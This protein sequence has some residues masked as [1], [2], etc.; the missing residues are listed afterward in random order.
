MASS[1][2]E[3]MAAI[4]ERSSRELTASI[5]Q[6]DQI[7]VSTVA[8]PDALAG[9]D[10][11]CTIAYDHGYVPLGMTENGASRFVPRSEVDV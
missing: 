2:R 7:L 11:I 5:V 1:P 8:S 9:M 4:E 6:G 10:Q 3:V